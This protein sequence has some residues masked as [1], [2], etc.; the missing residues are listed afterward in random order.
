MLTHN[1]WLARKGR[2]AEA[3]KALERLGDG[4]ALHTQQALAVIER[5]IEI[6]ESHGT[7]AR[8]VDLFKGTDLR[9]T[10]I[11]CGAYASQNFAGNL[12]AN[13]A[14]FFFEREYAP[15]HHFTTTNPE[16]RRVSAT[17]RPLSSI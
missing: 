4:N 13:Q 15:A 11:C 7:K 16:Q 9:R 1:R 17:T 8:I 3:Q 10:L 2:K 5:T 14:V 12:I 6:E